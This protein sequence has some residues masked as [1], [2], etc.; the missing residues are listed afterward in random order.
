M[1]IVAG[2]PGMTGAAAL[3]SVAAMR[4]GAG[5]VWLSIPGEPAPRSRLVEV[6]GKP[7]PAVG[8]AVEVG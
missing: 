3:A 8:W 1:R 6:V 4:A 2:S 7:C 5:I